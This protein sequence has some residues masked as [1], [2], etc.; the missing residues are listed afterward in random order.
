MC[1][2]IGGTWQGAGAVCEYT[3]GVPEEGA[4]CMGSL[5]FD[6]SESLCNTLGGNWQGAFT[7][8]ESTCG[9]TVVGACCLGGYCFDLPLDFCELV[10]GKWQGAGVTC[11]FTC[12]VADLGACCLW[13]NCFDSSLEFC[14][15]ADGDWYGLGSFCQDSFCDNAQING[16][17][18]VN[19]ACV[20]LLENDCVAVLGSFTPN[21]NC[22]VVACIPYCGS[23]INN[24]GLVD[25]ND[26]MQIISDWGG[27][28]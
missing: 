28:Q 24:D 11:E 25:V 13:D 4:C 3:C 9:A 17:C 21:E 26:I 12:D 18:C 16:S 19:G 7:T 22:D 10:G 1:T 15:I 20:T 8:C 27:C 5:C 6:S 2:L 14:E 23:D